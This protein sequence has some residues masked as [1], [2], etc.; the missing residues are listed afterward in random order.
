MVFELGRRDH[1]RE[2]KAK[3]GDKNHRGESSETK[4]YKFG[5]AM[6]Q[7]NS[8]AQLISNRELRLL[9]SMLSC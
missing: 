4:T 8:R 5:R 9:D 6:I 3:A 7:L 2:M 1:M